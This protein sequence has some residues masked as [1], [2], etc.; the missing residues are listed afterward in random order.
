MKLNNDRIIYI[1]DDDPEDR[2]FL[3]EAFSHHA[4]NIQCI[5]F[6]N[7]AK[8]MTKLSTL[9]ENP[10]GIILLDLNMPGISGKQ[11][12]L[13]L[14]SNANLKHIPILILTTSHLAADK[15]I[16]YELGANCFLTKPS[17]HV[18]LLEMA[19]SILNLWF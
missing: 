12:L 15:R 16:A 9:N 2:E 3:N 6:E 8:L 4:Q 7:G 13:E 11:I 17:S 10:P 14:K 18:L 19:K 5:M 1:V